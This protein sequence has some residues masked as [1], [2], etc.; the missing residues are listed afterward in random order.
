MGI[1]KPLTPEEIEE[2]VAARLAESRR[3]LD[4]EERL[5]REGKPVETPPKK[6][7]KKRRK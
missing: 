3:A 7:R 1:L 4:E 2:M 5:Y 6:K